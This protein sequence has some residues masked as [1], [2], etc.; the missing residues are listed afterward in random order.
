MSNGML[1][2]HARVLQQFNTDSI[3]ILLLENVSQGAVKI[4][5]EQ[6]FEVD[7]YT[8][9]WSEDELV[10]KIGGY[11]AI[12]I[13]SKTRLTQRVFDAAHQL[14]VVGCFC[15]GT[16][17]VDLSA[18]TKN[19][20]AV[21]NSPFANSRSV[22]ELVIA[23][24][25]CLSRLLTDRA[26]EMRQGTWNKVSKRC[27][28]LRGKLLGI[29]G[30]GHIGSQLSVLAESM[31]MQ[32]IYHDVVPLMPLGSARQADSL[33]ELLSE[34]DFVSIH[35]PELPETRGMIGERELSLMKPGAYLINNAR[36]TVV[37]I[38]ALVEALKSQHIG[39]CALDVYPREPAKNGVNAFNNDLNEW[40]SE[41]QSQA[42]VIMTPHIGGSTEE[43]Q[44]A[45]GVEVSNALCRYLNFGVS[46]GAVNFPEVNLRPITEQEVRSIRLCY[47]HHNQPGALLAVNEIIGS[48]NVDKQI[49]DSLKDIAYLL[50]DISDVSESDIQDIH[51]RL[52]KTPASILV[53]G[54]C[55]D[56]D[57]SSLLNLHS[58]S[59]PI[60]SADGH[61]L[62]E[63]VS[64]L[65]SA[66]IEHAASYPRTSNAE[67]EPF[68]GGTVHKESTGLV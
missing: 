40:A 16:N 28:E 46:T 19:G 30:Y 34:A 68:A 14:L 57:S 67:R 24:M 9:A 61:R 20:V 35:V 66:S 62:V 21:F 12:G 52:S 6:G 11:H 60:C 31:G 13:R 32:V 59:T 26:Q 48:H 58:L 49:T 7:F 8:G 1:Q 5:R 53:R 22:A 36:G 2:Q 50:A 44:R 37:Q 10:E 56:P 3:K 47:V 23:E 27:F 4:L 15:I 63:S 41:L 64:S 17:Q 43:A 55:P 18:A 45:I 25:M 54:P 29:V 65:R 42:N 51:M 33:E 39:G 38:P